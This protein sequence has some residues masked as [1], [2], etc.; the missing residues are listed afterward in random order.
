MKT[1]IKEPCDKNWDELEP[2]KE[3]GFCN[4]CSKTVIDFTSKSHEEII[5]YINATKEKNVCGRMSLSKPKKEVQWKYI[6]IL[7]APFIWAC[8]GLDRHKTTLGKIETTEDTAHLKD[9]LNCAPKMGKI[10]IPAKSIPLV[11]TSKLDRTDFIELL[12]E[13]DIQKLSDKSQ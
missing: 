2:N 3:G 13:V 11:D 5:D 7:I 6:T 8:N 9:S 4:A 12:G 10:Q 1:I